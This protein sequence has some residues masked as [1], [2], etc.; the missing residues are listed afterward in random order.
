MPELPEVESIAQALQG[1]IVGQRIVR[2]A[3]G[4]RVSSRCPTGTTQYEG[5]WMVIRPWRYSSQRSLAACAGAAAAGVTATNR[6]ANRAINVLIEKCVSISEV[7]FIRSPTMGVFYAASRPASVN[8]FT[9]RR[10]R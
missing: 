4:Q 9:R 10:R 7:S 1:E 5:S 8:C 3:L 2:F 6:A